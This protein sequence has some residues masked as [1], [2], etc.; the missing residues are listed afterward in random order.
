MD[1]RV[2]EDGEIITE[3]GAYRMSIEWYHQ[4]CCAG[5]SISS[6][7]LRTIELQSPA[8]FWAYSTLNPKRFQKPESDALNFGRAA[9]ALLLGDEVFEDKFVVLQDDAPRRPTK[10]QISARREGRV[11]EVA[12]KSFYYWDQFDQIAA[13]RTI[14]DIAWMDAIRYM[15][16][17][18]AAHPL[19]GPLFDGHA[20]VSLIWQ[21]EPTGV[22]LKARPDMLPR[23][24]GVKGDLK[25]AADVSLRAV[26]RDIRKFGYDMQA[27]L[28]CI[29]AELV[30]GQTIE[31]DV[32]VFIQ[33][34]PPFSVTPVEITVD[35]MHW[36]KLRLRRGINTFARCLETGDWP[37]PV[38]GIP[39]FTVSDLERE[40]IAADQIAGLLPRD[41]FE[42]SVPSAAPDEDPDFVDI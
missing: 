25:T 13:G 39:Q 41:F 18:L 33:K 34:Q 28:G 26:M 8:D 35:A 40:A 31:S 11:S 14:I 19:V 38:E 4:Q 42:T 6:G 1:L 17:A 24:G 36:S 16:E 7:G 21:D 29:G 2:V 15:S 10:A 22:W 12:K 3:P 20:E 30:L 23:L 32:T 5:P 27:A 9:H 37:G